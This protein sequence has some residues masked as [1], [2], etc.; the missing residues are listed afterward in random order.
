MRAEANKLPHHA[1]TYL[2]AWFAKA[3]EGRMADF[4][5]MRRLD[6][7]DQVRRVIGPKLSEL[8]QRQ[9]DL[10]DA[11]LTRLFKKGRPV[12]DAEIEGRFEMI[13]EQVSPAAHERVQKAYWDLR[14]KPTPEITK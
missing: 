1:K 12:S 11:S 10:L 2:G 13:T 8:S 14:L 9:K 7:I 3:I 4:E 6:F 5:G